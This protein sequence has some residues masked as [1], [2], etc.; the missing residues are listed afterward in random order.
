MP[1]RPLPNVDDLLSL[2][3][4]PAAPPAPPQGGGPRALPDADALLASSFDAPPS[5]PAAD[6]GGVQ[7]SGEASAPPM[8]R[9]GILGAI[10]ETMKPSPQNRRQE[11]EDLPDWIRMPEFGPIAS[12]LAFLGTMAT[13]PE[14]SKK[15]LEAQFPHLKDKIRVDGR[16]M[17]MKSQDGQ[18]YAW[19]PGLRWSDLLRAAAGATAVLPLSPLAAAG[20]PGGVAA[21]V[22]GA[23]GN[24]LAQQQA[25][26]TFDSEQVALGGAIG[27]AI[28][29]GQAV[30][31]FFTG[32]TAAA[33]T[34]AAAAAKA[35]GQTF[36]EGA[37]MLGRASQG[38]AD[39]VA[40][41]RAFIDP[42]Q[43]VIN[44]ANEIG[45]GGL[46]RPEHVARNPVAREVFQSAKRAGT[47]GVSEIADESTR[48]FVDLVR[49]RFTEWGAQLSRGKSDASLRDRMGAGLAALR[50]KTVQAFDLVKAKMP[51]DSAAVAPRALEFLKERVKNASADSPLSAVERTIIA[52]LEN[53]PKVGGL[54]LLRDN[55]KL[56]GKGQGPLAGMDRGVA[57]LV[58]GKLADD[59]LDTAAQYGQKEALEAARALS[60]QENTLKRGITALFGKQAEKAITGSMAGKGAAAAQSAAAGGD[61]SKLFNL[62]NA[63]PPSMRSEVVLDSFGQIVQKTGD[64]KAFVGLFD[65]V[66]ANPQLRNLVAGSMKPEARKGLESLVKV[67]RVFADAAAAPASPQRL[68]AAIPSVKPGLAQVASD[69]VAN[70]TRGRFGKMLETDKMKVLSQ[71]LIDEAGSLVEGRAPAPNM[72]RRFMDA[73]S[74]PKAERQKFWDGVRSGM[75]ATRALDFQPVQQE[76]R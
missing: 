64:L 22:L 60:K 45:A 63:I 66:E 26:G 18:D 62:Y 27:G 58:D 25:G 42:D 75:G 47:D 41:A 1:G 76:E 49:D 8:E 35:A 12:P 17:I 32:E 2:D 5:A 40:A 51:D 69:K 38:S 52:E 24:E 36:D 65:A 10:W 23:A 57:R 30:K 4:T 71:F 73:L 70:F 61:L 68:K 37:A 46:L 56:A 11:Y 54:N 44:A 3:F 9:P 39:D 29:A 74:V 7:L 14:E 31:R 33:E 21:G 15:I 16:Y 50:A 43:G 20:V 6:P 67:A 72:I 59:I 28:P 19:K 48:R 34:A 53:S 55:L 13:G